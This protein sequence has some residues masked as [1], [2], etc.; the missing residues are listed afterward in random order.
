MA[1]KRSNKAKT[2]N[3]KEPLTGENALV[4]EALEVTWVLKGHLKSAR[5]AYLRIGA[6]LTRVRDEQLYAALKHPDME[7][8]AEERLCLAKTSLYN[9]LKVYDW[10][11]R[12]HKEWL[13]P[14][15]KGFIPE[16]S[17]SVDLMW[18]EQ[19]LEKKDLEPK[20]RAALEE[21]RKKAL[22]GKLRENDLR[23][24]RGRRKRGDDTLK[25]ILAVLRNARKR[26][27]TLATD[28]S[29]ALSHLDAAI[30]ILDNTHTLKVAGLDDA[31]GLKTPV[32]RGL[33]LA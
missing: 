3:A 23:E 7:N 12:S 24:W 27:S 11:C 16:L 31:W 21:L 32:S 10:V 29:A 33:Y 4:Q 9:Y 18:I 19:E 8:Y 6:E 1:E 20:T 30:E 26:I 15:P 2:G 25:S 17:D 22:D 13:E 5:I 28:S 14:K